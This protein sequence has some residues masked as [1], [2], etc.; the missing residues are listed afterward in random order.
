MKNL[1]FKF[2]VFL[3]IFFLFVYE[4]I[5]SSL[6][7]ILWIYTKPK[8][9]QSEVYELP[10]EIKNPWAQIIIAHFIT[11][12]PGT[13]TIEILKNQNALLIHCLDESSWE[14]TKD[15][16]QNKLEPM[17]RKAYGEV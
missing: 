16:V 2:Y 1:L 11:L 10:L 9:L 13:L 3:W 4:L 14:G 15:L 7:V 12:T 8:R 5:L 6:K 17:L